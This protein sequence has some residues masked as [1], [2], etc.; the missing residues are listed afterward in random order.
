VKGAS[1]LRSCHEAVL[2][3]EGE[4]LEGLQKLKFEKFDTERG[5]QR[6]NTTWCHRHRP[7]T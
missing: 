2:H 5:A 4:V 6:W 3:G 1:N 7:V